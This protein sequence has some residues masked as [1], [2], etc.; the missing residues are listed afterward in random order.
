MAS[1][2]NDLLGS[3]EM[4]RGALLG[5]VYYL[6]NLEENTNP[7]SWLQFFWLCPPAPVLAMPCY[8]RLKTPLVPGLF[9]VCLFFPREGTYML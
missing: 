7:F 6:H 4:K 8:D 3:K 2:E 1:S 5:A 9:F